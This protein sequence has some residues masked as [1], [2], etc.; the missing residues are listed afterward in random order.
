MEGHR[1]VGVR[2]IGGA[3]INGRQGV[4]PRS[5]PVPRAIGVAA[6]AGRG[7]GVAVAAPA[8]AREDEPRHK[9]C[10]T[11]DGPGEAALEAPKAAAVRAG[12]VVPIVVA[13]DINDP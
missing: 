6:G 1:G 11:E 3:T 9:V 8:P 13:G 4:D 10:A 12:P 5:R 7:A 2:G